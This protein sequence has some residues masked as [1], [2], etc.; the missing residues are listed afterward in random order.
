LLRS[1]EGEKTGGVLSSVPPQPTRSGQRTDR[2]NKEPEQKT[3]N[4]LAIAR[5]AASASASKWEGRHRTHQAG[6]H[7]VGKQEKPS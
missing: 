6:R 7:N 4:V 5:R 3:S 2:Q 1:A